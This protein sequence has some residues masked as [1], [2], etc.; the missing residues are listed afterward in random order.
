MLAGMFLKVIQVCGQAYDE[1]CAL[2]LRGGDATLA[3]RCGIGKIGVLFRQARYQDALEL[4]ERTR[5]NDH[6]DA[7]RHV[8]FEVQV[9]DREAKSV[10]RRERQL[11][12]L[13]Q[14][15][16]TRQNRARVVRGSRESD[17]V[18]RLAE[19]LRVEIKGETV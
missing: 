5:G 1:A 11:V 15:V 9:I 19:R 10:R 14:S 4:A 16:Y 3:A 7:I 6:L 8:L 12:P 13:C 2:A 18:D 17:A